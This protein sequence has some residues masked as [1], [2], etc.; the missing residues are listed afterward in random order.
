MLGRRE[1]S[2]DEGVKF[3]QLVKSKLSK[4]WVSEENKKIMVY[5]PPKRLERLTFLQYTEKFHPL[6]FLIYQVD[7][8]LK[9][10]DKEP[11][12]SENFIKLAHLGNDL[13]ILLDKKVNGI[14]RKIH[15][16]TLSKDLFDKTTYEI[17][18]AAAYARAGHSV[19]FLETAPEEGRQ[20]PDLLIDNQ[21]EIECKK[22]DNPT[23]RDRQNIEQ[24][25]LMARKVSLQME[26]IGA[27]YAIIVK[28]QRDPTNDDVK[29]ILD[30]VYELMSSGKEG[31]HPF[32]EQGI[33]ITTRFLSKKN[34]TIKSTGM[35]GGTSEDLD[36]LIIAMESNPT[37]EIIRNPRV[38]GFKSAILPDRIRG[39]VESAKDGARQLTG[40]GPGLVYINLNMID[41]SLTDHDFNRLNGLLANLLNNNSTVSAVVIT[42]EFY[43]NDGKSAIYSHRSKVLKN[44]SARHPVGFRIIGEPE[45]QS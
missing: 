22:K 14:E 19:E 6:A 26:N 31:P 25:N 9:V 24:W 20:T 16:M 29:F 12:V 23:E 30:R 4:D 21:V 10:L 18:V 44:D 43:G 11:F 38:F 33:G 8:E 32:P 37:E 17:Q 1:L 42:S 15:E 45:E 41:R 27:N 35:E 7:K 2:V 36:H 39:V 5:L 40:D 13:A 3:I 34:E 28:T